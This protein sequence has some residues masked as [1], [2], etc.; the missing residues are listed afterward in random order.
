MEWTRSETLA[1]ALHN[2]THCHGA[3]LRLTGKGLL[4][5]CNCVLRSIFRI[6]WDRFV[7]CATQERSVSRVSVEPHV[8]RSRPST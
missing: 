7:R 5:P 1:L 4:T 6:C 2:C 3:G 8:G